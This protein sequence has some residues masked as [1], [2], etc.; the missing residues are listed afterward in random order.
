MS[1]RTVHALPTDV[2]RAFD[3]TVT[4]AQIANNTFLGSG[5]DRDALYGMIE[6][7]EAEFRNAT[8]NEMRLSRVGSPG[9]RE[10]YEIARYKLSGHKQYRRTFSHATFDY[11][12]REG[13]VHLENERLLPFDSA[14]G[15]EVYIYKGLDNTPTWEDI[16]DE[17]GDSWEIVNYRKGT[18]SIDPNQ[19]ERKHSRSGRNGIGGLGSR[20][21]NIRLSLTYRYG[22]LGGSR[23]VAGQTGL[24]GSLNETET[25]T[26]S[27]DDG[28][29][30][31]V[32]DGTIIVQIEEEY[33]RVEPDPTNDQMTVVERGV[34]GTR[35]AAH[36]STDDVLYTP[37]AVRKAVAARAGMQLVQSARYQDFLPDSEAD[38]DQSD[39]LA[40]LQDT[41]EMTVAALS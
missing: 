4:D 19:L 20:Q 16:T 29:V 23:S 40:E 33:L 18:L 14:A 39:V 21:R 12:L 27:V 6:D 28:S 32:G 7:A 8:N 15:D 26:V 30:F 2:A 3:T 24:D 37:P 22:T 35:G 17:E 36:D 10:S 9:T 13:T 31:P 11:S 38:M 1:P 34:R 5:D 41:Y 25:T